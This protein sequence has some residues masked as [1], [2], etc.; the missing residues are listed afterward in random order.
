MVS[1][2][3]ESV[4]R[5]ERWRCAEVTM[6]YLLFVCGGRP[7]SREELADACGLDVKTV[8]NTEERALRK[9]R[10]ALEERGVHG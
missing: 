3:E 1:R 2:S 6:D 7:M 9:V 5:E 8:K 4:S 10:R